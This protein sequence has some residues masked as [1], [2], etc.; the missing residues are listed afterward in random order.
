MKEE[1]IYVGT[2]EELIEFFNDNYFHPLSDE[3]S[4]ENQIKQFRPC[5]ENKLGIGLLFHMVSGPIHCNNDWG[6]KGCDKSIV[7]EYIRVI[8]KEIE[9]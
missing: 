2:E 7:K 5:D 1:T 3:L 8:E 6:C 4:F 9:E